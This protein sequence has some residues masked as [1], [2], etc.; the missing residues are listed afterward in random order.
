VRALATLPSDL[1]DALVAALRDN[2][3]LV[4][5]LGGKRHAIRQAFDHQEYLVPSVV[6]RM[7]NADA[8]EA[9]VTVAYEVDVFTKDFVT[10][11]LGSAFAV[12]ELVTQAIHDDYTRDLGDLELWSDFGGYERQPDPESGVTQLLGTM[13]FHVYRFAL[14]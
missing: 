12:A 9:E 10:G 8:T 5:A 11:S 13:T 7:L 14:T 2:V 6:L 3:A 4:T 1:S